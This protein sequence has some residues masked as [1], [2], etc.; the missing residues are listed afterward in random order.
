MLSSVNQFSRL[1]QDQ[2]CCDQQQ[3][4]SSFLVSLQK[5]PLF[6]KFQ[7]TSEMVTHVKFLQLPILWLSGK[8]MG[9]VSLCSKF[10][11]SV[12][13]RVLFIAFKGVSW[14][15][16]FPD[17]KESCFSK[18][19]FHPA[20]TKASILKF[21]VNCK[22]VH[23]FWARKRQIMKQPPWVPL[24]QL[25]TTNLTQTLLFS[26]PWGSSCKTTLRMTALGASR[27]IP[28]AGQGAWESREPAWEL[29]RNLY[30]PQS[31]KALRSWH[32]HMA[33][34]GHIQPRWVFSPW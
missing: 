27:D 7:A 19:D 18:S 3:Q 29:P 34:K 10:R 21:P 16:P 20:E 26:K 32:W 2:D 24:P 31:C 9:F 5:K 6:N 30:V 22:L 25:L 1:K 17:D 11:L 28:A 14:R 13:V 4:Y 33:W 15:D 23:F 8:L 12:R